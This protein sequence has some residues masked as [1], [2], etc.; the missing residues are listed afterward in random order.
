MNKLPFSLLQAKA[1]EVGYDD[2]GF[3]TPEI[4]QEDIQAYYQWIKKNYQG[5]L[6]YMQN[7][8]RCYPEK[9]LEGAKSAVIFITY[10]KQTPLA[11]KKNQGLVAAYARAKDYHNIHRSRLKKIVHWIEEQL[12]AK[13]L[14]KPFSD[15]VPILERA[16][17]VKAGLGWIGKNTLLI[18]R[19]FG[20][21]TL[22]SGLLL[23]CTIE[24][25]SPQ[26]I[27]YWGSHYP[28]CGS[29]TR[30]I[31][32]CPVQA[33]NSNYQLDA[34]R[35]LSYHLI[36][37]KND[38]PSEI[39]KKNPGYVFGCDICQD[40][41]PHNFRKKPGFPKDFE[42]ETNSISYLDAKQLELI[43]DKPESL[44]SRPLKRAGAQKLINNLTS[45]L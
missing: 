20:S 34:K 11:F 38:I 3:T 7:D 28:R 40:S 27:R 24:N 43:K 8:L 1:I 12:D 6:A 23:K 35:C 14:A 4:P 44:W 2:I 17:A 13:D 33:L 21:F 32:A 45:S 41:C 39:A 9:L 37:S 5:D 15:S 31:D 42:F 10:Y 19:Y 30:C 36:E 22:L 26:P 29:C 18:H 16:L 25:D